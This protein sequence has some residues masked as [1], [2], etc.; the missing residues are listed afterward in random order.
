MSRS[1]LVYPGGW[2]RTNYAHSAFGSDAL[3]TCVEC[4]YMTCGTV[5]IHEFDR[6]EAGDY[7]RATPDRRVVRC[8]RHGP[9]EVEAWDWQVE[10]SISGAWSRRMEHR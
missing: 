8:H 5:W 10:P 2:I 9:S 3:Q 6:T 7:V 4:G 1:K